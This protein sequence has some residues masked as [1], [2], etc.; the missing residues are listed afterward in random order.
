VH[1][2]AARRDVRVTLSFLGFRGAAEPVQP[3]RTPVLGVDVGLHRTAQHLHGLFLLAIVLYALVPAFG[4]QGST[5]LFVI[6]F[7]FILSMYGGGFATLP[8]YLRDIFGTMHVGAIHG[9]VLTA[10]S[11]AGVL[12]PV[13]VNYIRQYQ[14]EG[15]IAQAQA[16]SATMYIMCGLLFVGFLCNFAMSP[17]DPRYFYRGGS[18]GGSS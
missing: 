14:I 12:G 6:A 1:E 3:G 18:P 11:V 2:G 7:L 16:Y 8:A 9:R 5:A 4:R 13:L 15:G 17:V 10:W